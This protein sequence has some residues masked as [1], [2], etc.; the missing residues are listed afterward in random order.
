MAGRPRDEHPS[1]AALAMRRMRER[2]QA[3]EVNGMPNSSD[4]EKME[5]NAAAEQ[6][7]LSRKMRA[8]TGDPD[9][10]EPPPQQPPAPPRQPLRSPPPPPP[11]T[12]SPPQQPSQAAPDGLRGT[13]HFTQS[14]IDEFCRRGFLKTERPD[15]FTMQHALWDLLDAAW[16]ANLIPIKPPTADAVPER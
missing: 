11:S 1:K 3:A 14:E 15:W 16:A 13:V 6:A 7:D 4:F 12:S 10:S 8:A 2:R 9:E 5:A